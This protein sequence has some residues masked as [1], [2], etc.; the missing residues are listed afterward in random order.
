MYNA[1]AKQYP[2]FAKDLN[3]NIEVFPVSSTN[4]GT[5]VYAIWDTG[6]S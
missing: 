3:T 6:T 4:Q 5:T 1:F 2:A